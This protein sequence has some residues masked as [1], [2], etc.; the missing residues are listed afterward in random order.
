[1]SDLY[2]PKHLAR[3]TLRIVFWY[4]RQAD[5]IMLPPSPLAPAPKGFEKIECRYAADVDMWSR[6]LRRQ[7][8]R[9]RE[10]TDIERFEYEGKVQSSIIEEM[11][12]CLAKSTDETNRRFMEFFIKQAEAKRASRRMEV[13]ETFMHC[14]A[15][16]NVAP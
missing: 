16:E 11:K 14:E 8:K 4:C 3:K 6:R 5:F 13:V 2:I 15:K 10:M 9:M 1:M 12:A 7:E